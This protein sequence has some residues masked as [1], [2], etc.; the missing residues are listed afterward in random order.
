[1]KCIRMQVKLCAAHDP[2]IVIACS[3][4]GAVYTRGAGSRTYMRIHRYVHI[5][6]TQACACYRQQRVQGQ[7]EVG[8]LILGCTDSGSFS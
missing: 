2:V 3:V 8:Q 4:E 6:Y 5:I 1:M 7:G